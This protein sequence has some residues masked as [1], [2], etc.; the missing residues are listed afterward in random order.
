MAEWIGLDVGGANLKLAGPHGLAIE[1]AFPLW[2]R[3]D[4]LAA[5]IAELVQRGVAHELS[6]AN[7]ALTMTGEL[8]D[9]YRTKR[10]GVHHIIESVREVTPGRHVMVYL[11]G[12][13]F[14]TPDEAIEHPY[15]A[16]ASN[17]HALAQLVAREI[18]D[19]VGLLVDVGSTTSD[20][21]PIVRGQVAASGT[22]DTS[23]LC[24]G[25]LVYSGVV[26]TPVAALVER[27]PYRDAA[28]PVAAE[29]FAATG[30]VYLLLG[31]LPERPGCVETCDGRPATRE[32]ALDRLSRMICADRET[33]TIEDAL[34]A[35]L[36]VAEAQVAQLVTAAQQAVHQ[37][38]C[39]DLVVLSGQGEWLGRRLVERLGWPARVAS[40]AEKWGPDVSRVAP[41]HAVARLA[42]TELAE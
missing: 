33:F 3:R 10:E 17:W 42:A 39:P 13:R 24:A 25:E 38:G 21:I 36:A 37:H 41:A 26:R 22:S 28:C 40:L 6:S 11:V 12:G 19:G 29:L 8:A 23:R 15:L 14:V 7:I 34:V 20:L 27:L 18:A 5:A 9:C 35:A 4:E 31:E 16:A 32:C 2:R 30:D 1:T